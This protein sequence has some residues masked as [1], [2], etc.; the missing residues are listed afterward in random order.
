M[1]RVNQAYLENSDPL[2]FR[3][4]QVLLVNPASKGYLGFQAIQAH[5]ADREIREHLEQT[6][7]MAWMAR[8]ACLDHLEIVASQERMEHLVFKVCQGPRARKA[9]LAHLV[10]PATKDLLENRETLACQAAKDLGDIEDPP[11]L[12][13]NLEVQDQLVQKDHKD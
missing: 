6:A 1:K 13:G 8:Q 7:R 9:T 4:P 12:K 10:C 2:A 11:D 3:V 5:L